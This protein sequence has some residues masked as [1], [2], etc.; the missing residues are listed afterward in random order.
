MDIFN[1][2]NGESVYKL[3]NGQFWK[4]NSPY[5]YAYIS[6]N[7]MVLIYSASN[8]YK[9]HVDGTTGKMLML[10]KFLL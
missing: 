9:M 1:G 5:L 6:I 3:I 4:Q 2:W 8:G 7:P 10:F